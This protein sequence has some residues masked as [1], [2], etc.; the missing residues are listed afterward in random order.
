M[1]PRPSR[2]TRVTSAPSWAATRA[3]SYPPGPPPTITT[4]VTAPLFQTGATVLDHAKGGCGGRESGA[5]VARAL[6][7]EWREWTGLPFDK[8]GDVILPHALVHCDTTHDYAVYV[9][10]NVWMRHPI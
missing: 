4:R 5:A 7:A 9:G 10:P 6:E 1:P 3:A 8:D 2:S